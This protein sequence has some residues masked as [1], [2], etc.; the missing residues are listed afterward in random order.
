MLKQIVT[1]VNR[2]RKLFYTLN[3]TSIEDMKERIRMIMESQ[4]MSQLEFAK[5]LGIPPSTLSSIFTGRTNPTNKHTQAIHKA[6]PSVNINW[7]M[8]GEGKM[9]SEIVDATVES[10]SSGASDML[11]PA[12][13]EQPVP[14]LFSDEKN[15]TQYTKNGDGALPQ[16]QMQ[17]Y[18]NAHIGF[19]K[20]I[21]SVKRNIKEIRVFYDDG[22]YESFVPSK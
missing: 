17:M 8:F 12:S 7:L 5:T 15:R 3:Y 10:A 11:F 18:P 14:S 2:R 20:N 16:G 19:M 22:T 6:F 4:Q 13:T 1:F 21:D 9:L